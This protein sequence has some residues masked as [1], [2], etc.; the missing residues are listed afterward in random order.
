MPPSAQ[1]WGSDSIS[2]A[3]LAELTDASL[4]ARGMVHMA[5]A[6]A[7][8]NRAFNITNGDLIR[9]ERLWPRIARLFGLEP[10]VVRTLPIAR[11]MEDKEPVWARIVAKHG[12]QP[13]RLDEVALWGFAD[14]VFGQEYDVISNLNRL[15]QSG[16]HEGLDTGQMLLGQL[17]QYRDARILP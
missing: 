10:G 7:C 17:Q 6:P 3:S 1:S 14:F 2:R 9:W 16:F 13:K 15:R 12:L 8:E 4:F 11:W 5:T